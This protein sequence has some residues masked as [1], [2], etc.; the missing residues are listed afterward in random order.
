MKKKIPN[1]CPLC[2]RENITI[3]GKCVGPLCD[4]SEVK[5]LRNEGVPECED[6]YNFPSKDYFKKINIEHYNKL[7]AIW[8]KSDK[9]VDYYLQK[10]GINLITIGD[11]KLIVKKLEKTI[12]S[13]DWHKL[14]GNWLEAINF[15]DNT[16][17][18]SIFTNDAVQELNNTYK[19]SDDNPVAILA[20]IA[21]QP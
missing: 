13:N 18:L 14:F 4:E 1:S 3:S 10:S 5:T 12:S 21:T 7:N 9:I 15:F 11:V 17:E 2:R 6:C 8:E 20:R 16:N 19:F